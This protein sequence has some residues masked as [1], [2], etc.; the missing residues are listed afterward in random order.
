MRASTDLTNTY[1]PN[2][3]LSAKIHPT[4]VWASNVA[5]RNQ[6]VTEQSTCT[7]NCGNSFASLS[8]KTYPVA[9]S[10][11]LLIDEWRT[12]F[13]P[14]KI[15]TNA[16]C[17]QEGHEELWVWTK[18]GA[19]LFQ[20][21]NKFSST[22]FLSLGHMFVVTECCFLK[23]CMRLSHPFTS[24]NNRKGTSQR[25]HMHLYARLSL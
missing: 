21:E 11:W 16:C 24:Q 7:A 4:S 13:H 9:V 25:I 22:L 14:N 6:T 15:Q 18:Q 10:L 2:F 12:F 3:F 5:W 20:S 8:S 23:E 1:T 17:L 19:W